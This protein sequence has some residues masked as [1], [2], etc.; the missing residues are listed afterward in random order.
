MNIRIPEDKIGYNE[1]LLRC[2]C[3]SLMDIAT[4]GYYNDDPQ[5]SIQSHLNTHRGFCE[6]LWIAF[7]YIFKIRTNYS[8]SEIVLTD[9]D[10]DAAYKF[11][12]DY[13]LAR[14]KQDEEYAASKNKK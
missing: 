2:E 10:A 6:R 4:M 9:E 13:K 11:L 5:W 14:I 3:H 12:D 1:L 8:Y 7:K